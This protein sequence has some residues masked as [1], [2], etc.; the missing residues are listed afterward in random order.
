MRLLEKRLKKMDVMTEWR[1]FATLAVEWLGMPVEAMP[2]YSDKRKYVC[3]ANCLCSIIMASGN[4]GY[5]R[6][7]SYKTRLPFAIR[8]V[9]SLYYRIYDF[10]KQARIFPL[11]SCRAFVGVWKTGIGVVSKRMKQNIYN[12]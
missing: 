12:D 5:N 6:D 2:L 7:L 8:M 3:K 9:I 1:T 4:F 11:N 10:V